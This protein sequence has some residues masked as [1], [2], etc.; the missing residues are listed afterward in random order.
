MAFKLTLYAGGGE[1]TIEAE[2]G[3]TV[4]DALAAASEAT[5]QPLTGTVY[6]DNTPARLNDVIRENQ[7][8][9]VTQNKAGG[10]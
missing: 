2:D 8:V 6:V 1:V 3:V 5:G 7:D 4:Q 9:V 10:R